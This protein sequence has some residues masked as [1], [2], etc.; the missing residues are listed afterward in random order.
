MFSMAAMMEV[1][2]RH[3]AEKRVNETVTY[4]GIERLQ[5]HIYS[6]RDKPQDAF[7]AIRYQD[8]WFW[9]DNKDIN[10]KRNFALLTIFM[11]L[12]ESDQKAGSPLLTIGG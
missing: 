1:P 10:S 6:S 2:V 4:S 8:Y 3:V 11:S 9:I 5:T 7:T 12:T